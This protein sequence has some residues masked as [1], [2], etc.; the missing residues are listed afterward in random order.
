VIYSGK[1]DSFFN[2]KWKNKEEKSLNEKL[3]SLKLLP[4]SPNTRQIND[5]EHHYI[6]GTA[7]QV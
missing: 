4:K 5:L 3:K 2:Q 7:L 1:F 6:L